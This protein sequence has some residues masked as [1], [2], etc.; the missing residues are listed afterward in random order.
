MAGSRWI[1]LGALIC[2]LS[3]GMGAFAAHSL[4]QVFAR[5]YDGG[6]RTVAGQTVPLASKFLNDFKTGAEYQMFHGL[7]L[8]ATG[9]VMQRRPSRAACIAAW[10]FTTGTL[11]FSGSLYVLTLTGV[12]KW[13]AVTRF[14]G[15]AFLIGWITLAIAATKP[16]AEPTQA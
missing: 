8:I 1:A 6:T 12:T 15:V 4:D 7:A 5:K 13:G 2:G 10:S 9:L 16:L 3:V 11:L 14:G